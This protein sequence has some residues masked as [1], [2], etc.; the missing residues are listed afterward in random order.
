M[1]CHL[2]YQI[3]YNSCQYNHHIYIKG[4]VTFIMIAVSRSILTYSRLLILHESTQNCLF[5]VN[6][7]YYLQTGLV[8][9]CSNGYIIVLYI[10]SSNG[11]T[12]NNGKVRS[13]G[14]TSLN[15]K[16]DI[17]NVNYFDLLYSSI[18]KHCDNKWK[19]FPR[20]D[21]CLFVTHVLL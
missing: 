21:L 16:L 2:N 14:F 7:L 13:F 17:I 18:T 12:L 19:L 11:H 5:S 9:Y 10:S 6:V 15:I 1:V 3:Q 8:K 4:N 20:F